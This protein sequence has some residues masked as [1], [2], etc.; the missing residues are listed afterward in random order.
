MMVMRSLPG[1]RGRMMVRNRYCRVNGMSRMCGAERSARV[2]G[3]GRPDDDER[4]N[5]SQ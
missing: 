4:K 2:A 1:G 5:E 3:E